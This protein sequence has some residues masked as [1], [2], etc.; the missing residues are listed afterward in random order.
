MSANSASCTPPAPMMAGPKRFEESPRR[1]IEPRHAQP[2]ADAVRLGVDA[3]DERHDHARGEHAPGGGVARVREERREQQR[4]D[5]R[6]IEQDGRARGGGE[7][8]IGIEDA[9]EQRLDRHEREIGEGDA[10]E[11][12]G[13]IEADRIVGETRREQ[14]DHLRRE[15]ERKRQQHEIDGDQRRGDLIGEQ[16]GGGKP[17]LLQG[18][19]IGGDEGRGKRAFGEDGAEMVGKPEG[20]EEG[21]GQRPGAQ[22]RGHDHVADEAG[23]ARDEG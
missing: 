6:Q 5:D 8:V 20:D 7:P 17:G 23:E 1:L 10:G 19:R 15:D 9:G 11:R 16:L 13:E 21:V 3:D 4:G 18:A 2:D 12:H 14:A 22:H